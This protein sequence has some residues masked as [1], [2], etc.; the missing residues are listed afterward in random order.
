MARASRCRAGRPTGTRTGQ[1]PTI[2][3][4]TENAVAAP[5]KTIDR[6]SLLPP[7]TAAT[8]SARVANGQCQQAKYK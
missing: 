1:R 8:A 2:Q 5:Q 7:T 6:G 4:S 3:A